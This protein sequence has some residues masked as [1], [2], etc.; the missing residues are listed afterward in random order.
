LTDFN[1]DGEFHAVMSAQW[2]KEMEVDPTF[3]SG[4]GTSTFDMEADASCI[5][6]IK[7]V[8]L[9]PTQQ[10]QRQKLTMIAL[11]I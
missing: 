5:F 2:A 10:L 4:V 9:T 3:A 7:L 1:G 6:N 11:S 8:C